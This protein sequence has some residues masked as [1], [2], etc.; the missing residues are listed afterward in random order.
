[1]KAHKII[2]VIEILVLGIII[3]GLFTFAKVCGSMGGM[4]GP[5]HKT[6]AVV[7][8][9]SIILILVSVVQI[10]LNNEK[11]NIVIAVIQS[12]GGA[13]IA[14]IPGVIA[15]VCKMKSMHCYVYTRPF[16]IILGIVLVGIGIVDILILLKKK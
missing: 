15:P 11:V 4:A 13:V 6:K 8:I 14:L 10:V 2:N 16:L 5:C 1:M 3:A 12:V 7:L 9:T